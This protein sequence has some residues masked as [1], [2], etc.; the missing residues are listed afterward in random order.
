MYIT[1]KTK[2]QTN[3]WDKLGGNLITVRVAVGIEFTGA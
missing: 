3:S 2:W 1:V